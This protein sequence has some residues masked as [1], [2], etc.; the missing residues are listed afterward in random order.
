MLNKNIVAI[1]GGGFGRSLG[2]LKIEKYITT[3]VKKER[4]KIFP[5]QNSQ[6]AVQFDH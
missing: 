4:P 3:L 1:G 2:E 5:Q 6:G